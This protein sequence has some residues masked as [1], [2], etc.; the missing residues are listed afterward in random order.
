MLDA[1]HISL[2]SSTQVTCEIAHCKCIWH[3]MYEEQSILFMYSLYK[4]C[5]QGTV[6]VPFLLVASAQ[7]H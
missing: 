4:G 2:S 5:T 1:V 7:L 6:F 3:K